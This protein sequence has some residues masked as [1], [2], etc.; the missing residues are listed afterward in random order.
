[1]R[2]LIISFGVLLLGF[3]TVVFFA[4]QN[5][6]SKPQRPS[7]VTQS[8]LHLPFQPASRV[9]LRSSP[10]KVFA[11]YFSPYPLSIDN[12]IPD[13]DYYSNNY[14]SPDGEKQRFLDKGGLLRQRPLPRAPVPNR[15]MFTLTDLRHEIRLADAIGL[16]GFAYNILSLDGRHWKHLQRMLTLLRTEP[17]DFKVL[18]MPDMNAA[19]RRKSDQFV[20]MVKRLADEPGLYRLQDGRLVIAPYLAERQSLAW[21]Q[22]QRKL[23]EAEGIAVALF[24]VY[25]NWR[26]ALKDEWQSSPTPGDVFYGVSNW[27]PRTVA[28]AEALDPNAKAAHEAGLK[29]MA[30]VATQDV[31]P[32]SLIF[33]E[34]S[35]SGA[36]RALWAHAIEKDADWVHIITWN[37]YSE[38]TE[39]EPS[40]RTG[41]A[42][43]DLAAY[44]IQWFKLGKPPIVRDTLYAFYRVHETDMKPKDKRIRPMKVVG[45]VQPENEIELLAFL[46]APGV[47]EIKINDQVH[48]HRAA[49]GITSFKVPLQPGTPEFRLLRDGNLV[50]S[51]AG[52][53]VIHAQ[54]PVHNLLYHG[55][56]SGRIESD[57]EAA[58]SP[59]WQI[60]PEPT[61]GLVRIAN[62]RSPLS[63][64]SN[65][66]PLHIEFDESTGNGFGYSFLAPEKGKSLNLTLDLRLD[67]RGLT[68][69]PIRLSLRNPQFKPLFEL[70]LQLQSWKPYQALPD[71]ETPV[72]QPPQLEAGQWYRVVITLA[73]QANDIVKATVYFQNVNGDILTPEPSTLDVSVSEYYHLAM[74]TRSAKGSTGDIYIDNVTAEI[75]SSQPQ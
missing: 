38:S 58:L 62:I 23:L 45:G 50:K 6:E 3:F 54:R 10:K 40:T 59:P 56:S 17:T 49:A 42:F 68:Q 12:R 52:K 48:R 1:M 13:E 33:N 55:M 11:H 14:L 31:R 67:M 21:W 19:L 5:G 73:P 46:T 72:I 20:A 22:Q 47:L 63:S 71:T 32:K 15:E 2:R 53:W 44:Y 37:D 57:P 24:P 25:H 35:N 8:H 4:T 75:V 61:M 9:E 26:K 18:L 16:D 51:M 36:F 65:Q 70:P 69:T 27:G 74:E 41:Y 30:P 29:W 60:D 64:L 39:I 43:Y 28:G 7:T 66:L 34:A